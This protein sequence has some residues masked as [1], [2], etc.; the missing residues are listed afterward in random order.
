MM[1]DLGLDAEPSSGSVTADSSASDVGPLKCVWDFVSPPFQSPLVP[2]EIALL[3][4][5]WHSLSNNCAVSNGLE[6]LDAECIVDSHISASDINTLETFTA[7]GPKQFTAGEREMGR[8][9]GLGD[10]RSYGKELNRVIAA[11]SWLSRRANAKLPSQV[12]ERRMGKSCP[13]A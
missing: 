3:T 11:D 1:N 2:L 10:G 12:R 9:K 6:L 13:S 8:A 4:A 5:S 7:G